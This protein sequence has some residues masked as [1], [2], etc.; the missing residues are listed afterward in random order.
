MTSTLETY[1]QD[2]F[3]AHENNLKKN[4]PGLT[5]RRIKQELELLLLGTLS[6]QEFFNSPYLPTASN[7]ATRF[8]NSLELG[9][10]LEYITGKAFFYRSEFSVTPDVLI[11][12]SET[13]QL[14]EMGIA[15]LNKW[16]KKTDETLKMI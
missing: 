3:K 12:R 9:I 5:V 10:P 1:T 6:T 15:E 2:F 16:S 13:E 8:F 14:V 7:P 4:Y 11:P